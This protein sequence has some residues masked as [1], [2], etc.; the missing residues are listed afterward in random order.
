M[1]GSQ[2]AAVLLAAAALVTPRALRLQPPASRRREPGVLV[3]VAGAALVLVLATA[4]PS[5][6]VAAALACLATGTRMRRGRRA[7]ARRAEG[8][9]L[10]AALEVLI[11]ELRV[12]AHPVAAFHAA[13]AES[14]G[15]VRQAFAAVAGRAQLGADAAGGIRAAGA[16][17]PV[18][19]YWNRMA[20]FWE[21]ASRHGL[22]IA[23]LMG[24]AHRDI[25]DRQRFTARMHAALAGARATAAI[26]AGLP[27]LGLALGELIGAHPVRFLLGGGVGGAFLVVGVALICA[28]LA[29]ADRII[30]RM[31]P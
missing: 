11:G 25:L 3:R 31:V 1:S 10:A 7:R 26:L 19:A 12:G 20:V 8:H 29:W 15:S 28:G 27:L 22:A 2:L 16:V 17:S 4:A 21:L 24:A 13:A 23:V 5:M 30:D 14:T 6:A 9:A 18:A